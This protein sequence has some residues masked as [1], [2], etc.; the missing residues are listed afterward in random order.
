MSRS[1]EAVAKRHATVRL[2]GTLL[3]GQSGTAVDQLTGLGIAAE[4]DRPGPVAFAEDDHH[5]VVEVE[6]ARSTRTRAGQAQRDARALDAPSESSRHSHCDR[7]LVVGPVD[8]PQGVTS[9]LT[10]G[11]PEAPWPRGQV[12]DVVRAETFE[13]SPSAF[14]LRQAGVEH[15]RGPP[16]GDA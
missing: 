6:E 7:S 14:R 1:L 2:A 12:P 13:I 5:L 15:N 3:R 10:E 11:S 16:T 4:L 9:G 8:Q